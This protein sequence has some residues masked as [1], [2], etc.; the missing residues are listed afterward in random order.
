[1][2]S[3]TLTFNE[4]GED[5]CTKAEPRHVLIQLRISSG[6][7]NLHYR[8]P[9]WAEYDEERLLHVVPHS[10]NINKLSQFEFQ[11][12]RRLPPSREQNIYSQSK[13]RHQTWKNCK[14]SSQ[15]QRE[16]PIKT[17]DR[18]SCTVSTANKLSLLG[19]PFNFINWETNG[20]IFLEY[21]SILC[22]ELL[23]LQQSIVSRSSM[24]QKQFCFA[25][26]MNEEL[27]FTEAFRIFKTTVIFIALYLG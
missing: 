2:D 1:M 9:Y 3:K 16:T 8:N 17:A 5:E 15:L 14:E 24:N 21:E 22:S 4:G 19:F 27:Y 13:N 7:I 10:E 12:I 26:K 25:I 11:S 20:S 18:S 6:G 23:L